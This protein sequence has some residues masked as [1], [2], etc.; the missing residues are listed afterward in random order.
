MAG[1]L[2][3]LTQNARAYV[4]DF[5]DRHW[6]GA[7]SLPS[8]DTESEA[9]DDTA[10]G[11]S[12]TTDPFTSSTTQAGTGLP[13]SPELADCYRTLDLPFGAPMAQVTRH[14][15][16]QLKQYH[17]DLYARDRAKQADATE[18]TR[19]LND[20]YHKIRAAWTRHQRSR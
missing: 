9:R 17:P 7:F 13:Y 16:A 12:Q 11:P 8:Q 1:L 14:W 4:N 18:V 15:K 2:E 10:Y 5:L 6:P 20:A 19:Q 3:R